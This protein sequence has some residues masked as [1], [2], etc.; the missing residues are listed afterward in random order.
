MFVIEEHEPL[1]YQSNFQAYSDSFLDELKKNIRAIR[2]SL[3]F[4]YF[5]GTFFRTSIS[6]LD[7]R[8]KSNSQSMNWFLLLKLIV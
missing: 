4:I 5:K 8:Q 2:N 7:Y 6:F 3:I 1:W